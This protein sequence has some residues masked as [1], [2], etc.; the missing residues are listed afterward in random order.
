MADRVFF[1]AGSPDEFIRGVSVPQ[2]MI[3]D[4]L[5][6]SRIPPPV[7]E[8]IGAS[9]EGA[10]GFLDDTRL[11]KLVK[12]VIPE[13][14]ETAAD[15]VVNALCN[16]R[17]CSLEEILNAL[18]EWRRADARHLGTFPDEAFASVR[19]VLPRLIRPSAALDRQREA[20]RLRALTGHQGKHVEIVCDARPVFD[21]ELTTIEGFV[22]KT[23]LKLMYETQSDD[24]RCIEIALSPELVGKL[25]DEAE[26]ARKKLQALGESI[27]RWIPE[28][29]AEHTS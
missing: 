11:E 5:Q 16:L 24:T 10:G 28:G 4:L 15:A 26:K 29:L 8:Q 18:E 21:R 14:D 7:I 9:V 23:T 25:L 12:E 3:S 2:Q 6:I 13:D 1:V 20:G 27:R 19:R 17:S 22:T